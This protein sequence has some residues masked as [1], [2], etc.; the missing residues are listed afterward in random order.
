[1]R[2]FSIMSSSVKGGATISWLNT[3]IGL[4]KRGVKL[5][6]AVPSIGFLTQ[7][8]DK[9]G[10]EY[11][12]CSM[13]YWAYP[14]VNGIGDV[15]K[16]IPKLFRVFYRQI[17]S[18]K[19]LKRE[20][21][22]WRPDVIHTNV[23]VINIGYQL[24]KKLKIPHIW[25]IREYG[26]L[27]FA[28]RSIYGQKG[29]ML[30]LDNGP[31]ISITKG[32]KS[33]FR[34]GSKAKVIYNGIEEKGSMI[35]P[36]YAERED[37]IIYVGRLT[38]AKGVEDVID[39]FIK[40]TQT[41]HNLKLNLIGNY[42][43]KYGDHLKEK[44]EQAGLK[45]RIILTGP[46]EDP[47]PEMQRAK[48]IIVAS[49]CEGF[50]RITAE[51]MLNGCL[52]IGKNTAGTKE[53]FDNG[54]S[55]SGEEIGIR[56]NDITELS[57]SILAISNITPEKYDRMTTTAYNVVTQLYSVKKNIEETFN[58]LNEVITLYNR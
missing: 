13:P 3:M 1:M 49:K 25:H 35:R 23:S 41:G 10:I 53:Q 48:A 55:L 20:M 14:R 21:E 58:Y 12:I 29:L 43:P 44:I 51:A 19:L 28:I 33:Y 56:Y 22:G 2:L 40:S 45:D 38:K 9:H 16:F 39:S 30:R 46:I 54:L 37:V 47:Y 7:E 26:V 52:V 36:L 11:L 31:A 4:K 42:E 27:D 8:L 18:Y 6:V 5:K 17:L 57:E 32:L 34:L 24:G 15:V 50:G